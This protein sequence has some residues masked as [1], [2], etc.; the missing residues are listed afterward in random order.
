MKNVGENFLRLKHDLPQRDYEI[1]IFAT[2]KRKSSQ[3][4]V[5]DVVDGYIP[6]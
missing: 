4:K 1:I 2:R 6:K 3:K 5:S